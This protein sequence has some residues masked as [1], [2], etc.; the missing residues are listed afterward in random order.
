MDTFRLLAPFSKRSCKIGSIIF[1]I[2]ANKIAKAERHISPTA[3][4]FYNAFGTGT[5][6]SG[7]GGEITKSD[8]TK[9]TQNAH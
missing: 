6:L 3:Q 2:P 5:E 7:L 8:G 1:G 9:E 4:D